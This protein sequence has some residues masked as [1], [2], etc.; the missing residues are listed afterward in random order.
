MMY[1]NPDVIVESIRKLSNIGKI[2]IATQKI[3]DDRTCLD[4]YFI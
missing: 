3:A 4:V 2:K 1:T